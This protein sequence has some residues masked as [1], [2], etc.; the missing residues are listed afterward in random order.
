MYIDLRF[1]LDR[2]STRLNS[3]H[4]IIINPAKVFMGDTGSLA[5]GGALT[6]LSI[7][8][9][10]ELLLLIVGLVYVIEALS[11]IIQVVSFQTTGKRVFRMS[12]IHHHF[13]LGGMKE[14][15]VVMMFWIFALVCGLLGLAIV[16]F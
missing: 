14:K 11:V 15:N 9:R 7:T 13:E 10:Y 8:T 5:L 3:S 12:P 16:G 2:K 4:Q 6:A 1:G